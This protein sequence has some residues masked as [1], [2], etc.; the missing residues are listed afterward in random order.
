MG[1]FGKSKTDILV[2]DDSPTV[3]EM[4]HSVLTINYSV[5]VADN[6]KKAIK[7]AE[8]KKP[9]LI[10]LDMHLP[11]IEGWE[12]CK[13]LKE[14]SSTKK[15]KILMCTADS[16]GKEVERAFEVG[17]EGYIIKPVTPEKLLSKVKDLI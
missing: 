4:L 9:S 13:I 7:M 3:L 10:V 12:V 6:G 11:D 17:A 2:V 5:E 15:I 1:L 14:S 8:K 16:K